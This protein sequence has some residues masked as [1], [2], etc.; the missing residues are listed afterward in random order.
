M[1]N[2]ETPTGTKS[3]NNKLTPRKKEVARTYFKA[4][5][6]FSAETASYYKPRRNA[7]AANQLKK[8]FKKMTNAIKFTTKA[9]AYNKT[10]KRESA[11]KSRDLHETNLDAQPAMQISNNLEDINNNETI[12]EIGDHQEAIGNESSHKKSRPMPS[13]PGNLKGCIRCWE[14]N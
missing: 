3:A 9:Q 10:P 13:T 12:M 7:N 2:S 14:C 1:M 4:R 11:T 5:G 8:K 6:L